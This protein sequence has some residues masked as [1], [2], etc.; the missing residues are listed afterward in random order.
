M[1]R[2]LIVE[3][4]ELNLDMLQRRLDR[5]GYEIIV[6][7]D[8]AS[9]I[10]S[11]TESHPDIILMDMSLPGVDGWEATRRLKNNEATKGIPIIGLSAHAMSEDR[12]RAFEVGCDDYETKPV[13]LNRLLAKIE[14]LTVKDTP[15]DHGDGSTPGSRRQ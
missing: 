6:A 12:T 1:K 8:G 13:H 3:D 2:I 5:L 9:G 10:R 7:V 14:K 15:D 4:N 11:A